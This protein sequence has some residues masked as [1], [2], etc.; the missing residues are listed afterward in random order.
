MASAGGEVRLDPRAR[1]ACSRLAYIA[2]SYTH[3]LGGGGGP[4]GGAGR[5]GA[6]RRR[7]A[8]AAARARAR[9]VA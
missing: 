5:G 6:A 2:Y 8:A 4:A 7:R 3:V 9:Q 1:A